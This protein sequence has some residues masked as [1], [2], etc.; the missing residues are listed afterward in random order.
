MLQLYFIF[1]ASETAFTFWPAIACRNFQL[2]LVIAQFVCLA[3]EFAYRGAERFI[4]AISLVFWWMLIYDFTTYTYNSLYL[5]K[6]TAVRDGETI[7]V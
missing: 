5:V 3:A 7:L 6:V 1:S 4:D 2:A